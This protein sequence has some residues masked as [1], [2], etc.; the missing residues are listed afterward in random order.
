M[1]YI[2]MQITYP[3]HQKHNIYPSFG[4]TTRVGLLSNSIDYIYSTQSSVFRT[5]LDWLKFAKYLGIHFKD[6]EKANVVCQACSD[7]SEPYTLAL[8]LI[9]SLGLEA[10]KKFFP[11]KAKDIDITNISSFAKRGIINL[12][13]EDI[14]KLKINGI[15][16]DKYFSNSTEQ[17]RLV[18]DTIN[19][20]VQTYKVNQNL[21]Q[22]VDFQNQNLEDDASR[23]VDDSNTI[24][25]CRNVLPYL[26]SYD[27]RKVIYNLGKNMKKGSILSLG[28]YTNS[29]FLTYS[30]DYKF[31]KDCGFEPLADFKQTYIK[32][33]NL[34]NRNEL[35]W[36]SNILSYHMQF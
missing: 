32:T 15:N 2:N 34:S 19:N 31:I 6:A 28:T 30:E 36:G 27:A 35:D 29:K 3:I 25:L 1:C 26:G 11:I 17:I 24:F 10:S 9:H 12:T 21:R 7:G 4:S 22:F 13:K 5:D 23:L 14:E 20:E 18:N 8:A 33:D 16:F